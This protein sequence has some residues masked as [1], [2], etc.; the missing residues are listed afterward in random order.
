MAIVNDDPRMMKLLLDRG[1]DIHQRCTGKFFI[2]DDQKEKRKNFLLNEIPTLPIETN[3]NG[4]SYF[5]EYPLNFAAV[6]DHE[7]CVRLL[8]AKGANPNK[9]DSNGNTILHLLVIHNN[10]VNK[11]NII[12][13]FLLS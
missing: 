11:Y 1:S 8:L 2:P 13:V 6:L 7:D 12:A 10:M 5:G 9:Q 4:L 3:Y